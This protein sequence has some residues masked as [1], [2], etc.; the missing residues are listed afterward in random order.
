M[1]IQS[2]ISNNYSAQYE[3]GS[4]KHKGAFEI[5]KDLHKDPSMRIVPIA[6]SKYYFE[7]IPVEE[8]ILNHKNIFDFCLRAK[9]DS[10]FKLEHH[11]IQNG[12]KKKDALSKT[13]R[14]Y[15]SN[16]GGAI[17]KRS[18]DSNKLIGINVGFITTIF[19]KYVKKEMDEYDINYSF[20]VR[21]C[22][23]IMDLVEDKQLSLW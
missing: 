20:Y 13:T 10:R 18:T 6:L 22:K 8:T 15:V 9:V 23:K 7:N 17:Y 5:D 4:I 19:N 3:G 11:S 16:K 1:K 14:Y 12:E 21:E 2:K